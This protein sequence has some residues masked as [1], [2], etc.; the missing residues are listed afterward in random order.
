MCCAKGR[1]AVIWSNMSSITHEA[2]QFRLKQYILHHTQVRV[3]RRV[4]SCVVSLFNAL[5]QGSG[6]SPEIWQKGLLLDPF[7]S[8]LLKS[9]PHSWQC[10]P[11]LSDPSLPWTLSWVQCANA[12][13]ALD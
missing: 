11:R 4:A 9:S 13:A 2:L 7:F 10:H 12:A 1:Y 8:P 3:W 5:V 6:A